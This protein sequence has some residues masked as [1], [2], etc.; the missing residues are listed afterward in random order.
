MSLLEDQEAALPKRDRIV[1]ICQSDH[2]FAWA[3]ALATI[4]IINDKA[5]NG[6]LKV[7]EQLRMWQDR[8]RILAKPPW[9]LARILQAVSDKGTTW[10]ET[11]TA[12]PVMGSEGTLT[13]ALGEGSD[14]RVLPLLTSFFGLIGSLFKGIWEQP[15]MDDLL[16]TDDNF[17]VVASTIKA[18]Y[19]QTCRSCGLINRNLPQK[20]GTVVRKLRIDHKLGDTKAKLKWLRPDN[21]NQTLRNQSRRSV[22]KK[23]AV[24]LDDNG[25]PGG[26][27]RNG[28]PLPPA[29]GTGAIVAGCGSQDPRA[30]PTF[31]KHCLGGGHWTKPSRARLFDQNT[32]CHPAV[33][34]SFLQLTKSV[35]APLCQDP[36]QLNVE[37]VWLAHPQVLWTGTALSS[38]VVLLCGGPTAFSCADGP[39]TRQPMQATLHGGD[40]SIGLRCLSAETVRSSITW[41]GPRAEYF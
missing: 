6:G 35:P 8:R 7:S 24:G 13:I 29:P 1:K 20:D 19:D 39:P 18:I 14:Y 11:M 10:A 28:K 9:I 26:N 5:F 22:K 25:I 38:T 2:R 15:E 36:V 40:E 31:S 12:R 21:V 3:H 37:Q 17:E 23:T 4:L 27:E 30:V 16:E 34:R 32:C 33:T 41:I